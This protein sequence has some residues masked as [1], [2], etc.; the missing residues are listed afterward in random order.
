MKQE[1]KIREDHNTYH[2]GKGGKQNNRKQQHQAQQE[3]QENYPEPSD[4]PI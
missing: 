1:G 4:H 2:L 3:K